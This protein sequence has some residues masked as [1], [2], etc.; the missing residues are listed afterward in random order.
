MS[1]GRKSAD[2]PPT[3]GETKRGSITEAVYGIGTVT[4]NQAYTFRANVTAQILERHVKEGD[5]VKA[6]APL[7][8]VEG[9]G[10]IRAPFEGVVTKVSYEK[11]EV[12]TPE[13]PIAVVT[14]LKNPY[15]LVSL[16]QSAAV[17]VRR[18][19]T[20]RLNFETL[21]D[22]SFRGEVR[23]L[24]AK[25]GQFLARIEV[26]DLPEGILPE[27]TADVAIEIARRENVLLAP[28]LSLDGGRVRLAEGRHQPLT[29]ET[30]AADGEWV[31]I[32]SVRDGELREGQ[33]LLLRGRR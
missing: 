12:A 22:R 18:G 26:E 33:R 5:S 27:M 32:K 30:G 25:D 14:D 19:Q 10:Q 15:V 21:R 9:M 7:F 8:V 13:A 17:R 16:D 4:P 3:V 24:Y 23:S 20:A 28:L 2:S 11:G 29:V 1:C 31:E 6:R